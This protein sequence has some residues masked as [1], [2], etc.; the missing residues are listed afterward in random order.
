MH[1]TLA[2]EHR[3]LHSTTGLRVVNAGTAAAC[4]TAWHSAGLRGPSEQGLVSQGLHWVIQW[5]YQAQ[6]W[7]APPES[8]FSATA[9]GSKRQVPVKPCTDW[10]GAAQALA[11]PP[12][13]LP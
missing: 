13:P 4:S 8:T 10:T 11:P 6:L 3:G 5:G 1:M 12:S 7:Q 2:E 9:P